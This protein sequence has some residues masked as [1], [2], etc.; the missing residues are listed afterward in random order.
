MGELSYQSF[1]KEGQT[2]RSWHFE[3]Q[4]LE[5]ILFML[6]NTFHLQEGRH[7]LHFIEVIHDY[8]TRHL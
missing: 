6:R 3:F 5:K 7:E 1:R 2:D 8:I 4:D